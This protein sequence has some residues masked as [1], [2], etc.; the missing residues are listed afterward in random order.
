MNS[1]AFDIIGTNSFL[2]AWLPLRAAAVT[3]LAAKCLLLALSATLSSL[4][5]DAFAAGGTVNFGNHSSSK[6]I[7]GH[8]SLPVTT[9]DNVRAALYWAP[10]G[11]TSFGQLGATVA[12]GTPLP[13]LFAG[14]TR[15]CQR[16]ARNVRARTN[17]GRSTSRPAV[18]SC[19]S[20]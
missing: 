5:L 11:S 4:G 15:P 7:N 8:S 18:I 6:I 14:G 12:V 1:K 16:D 13:G 20:A 17:S 3:Q 2:K 9:N 10:L 19:S